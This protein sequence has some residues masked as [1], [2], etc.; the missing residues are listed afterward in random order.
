MTNY[1]LI[2]LAVYSGIVTAYGLYA[3]KILRRWSG[4]VNDAQIEAYTTL[5]EAVK[6][7]MAAHQDLYATT[8][9]NMRDLRGRTQAGGAKDTCALCKKETA[10]WFI[11]GRGQVICPDCHPEGFADARRRGSA[12][13]G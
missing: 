7:I 2:A 4:A 13:Q 1:P 3:G 6:R 9:V 11:N 5:A 10:S 8:E 12:H